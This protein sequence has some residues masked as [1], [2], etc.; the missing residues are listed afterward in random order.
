MLSSRPH[1]F[2]HLF[3]CFKTGRLRKSA[4]KAIWKAETTVVN[5]IRACLGKRKVRAP[6]S[7]KNGTFPMGRDKAELKAPTK[8]N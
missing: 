4:V 5:C 3:V 2:N 6:G 8:G 7:E 1:L